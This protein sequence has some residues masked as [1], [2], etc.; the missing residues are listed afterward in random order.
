MDTCKILY[1]GTCENLKITVQ[2]ISHRKFR[3]WVDI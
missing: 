3:R 1:Q 2:V